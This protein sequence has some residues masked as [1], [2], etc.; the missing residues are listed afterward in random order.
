M[1]HVV[2]D[3]LAVTSSVA[4]AG[5]W[6]DNLDTLTRIAASIVA[7]VAGSVALYQRLKKKQPLPLD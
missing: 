1:K 5:S 6:I 7:I 3:I 4:A 2:A